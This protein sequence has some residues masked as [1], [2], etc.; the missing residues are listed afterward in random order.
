MTTVVAVLRQDID[1]FLRH[2]SEKLPEFQLSGCAGLNPGKHLHMVSLPL[3]LLQ[4]PNLPHKLNTLHQPS[5]LNQTGF[6][7]FPR[8][9][10]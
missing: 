6:D 8:L 1:D 4:L 2:P 3:L 5:G 9:K 10:Y 7:P